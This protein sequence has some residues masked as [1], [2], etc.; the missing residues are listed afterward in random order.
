MGKVNK[1]ANGASEQ[2]KLNNAQTV[3]ATS[4]Q[5]N[6]KEVEFNKYKNLYDKPLMWDG[7]RV[8]IGPEKSDKYYDKIVD[9]IY[10]LIGA[11]KLTSRKVFSIHGSDVEVLPDVKETVETLVNGTI[12][13]NL[14]LNEKLA[15]FK[16]YEWMHDLE[17]PAIAKSL[18]TPIHISIDPTDRMAENVK[19]PV[20]WPKEFSF[21]RAKYELAWADILSFFKKSDA[22]RVKWYSLVEPRVA[23]GN[24]LDN[25]VYVA[26]DGTIVTSDRTNF[27]PLCHINSGIVENL[28]KPGRFTYDFIDYMRDRI[29]KLCVDVRH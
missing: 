18:F 15:D 5:N 9:I 11:Y 23:I 7:A 14:I 26:E 2:N 4:Q 27:G 22:E 12:F 16:T 1:S 3:E 13:L 25:L 17:V 20:L 10:D 19:V 29:E 24:I 6:N 21:D 28:Y 8:V